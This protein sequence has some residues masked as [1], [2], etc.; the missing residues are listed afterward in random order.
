MGS[1]ANGGGYYH[2]SYS[3]VRGCDRIVPGRL[4]VPGRPPPTTRRLLYGGMQ[5]QA[6][7]RRKHDRASMKLD[8]LEA[9]RKWVL[10]ERLLK[11]ITRDPRAAELPS[12]FGANYIESR[13][14]CCAT[15]RAKF[16]AERRPLRL[17]ST[18]SSYKDQP[19]E[20]RLLSFVSHP[21][22]G[23]EKNWRVRLKV[24]APDDAVPVVASLTEVWRSVLVRARRPVRTSTA[25]SSTAQR[26][27]AAS[28][29]D[30]DF[31]GHPFRKDF[32]D[33]RAGRDAYDEEQK[34]RDLPAGHDQPREIHAPRIIRE[35]N[36]GRLTD[37][38]TEA[39][40]YT[41]VAAPP[42]GGG[43]LLGTARRKTERQNIKTTR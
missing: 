41:F 10:G 37:V 23:R 7:I 33:S 3:V 30:T 20:A 19:W 17:V 24:F 34:A 4:Y 1:C 38:E 32:Q 31:I 35:D 5:L 16:E 29:P 14:D 11:K 21:L 13:D 15:M 12:S 27:C 39:P 18:Y 40:S 6:T 28:C 2:Y 43:Q 36:Y 9:A 26:P 22:V 8:V 42:R 25:S